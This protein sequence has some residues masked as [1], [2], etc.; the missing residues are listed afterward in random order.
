MLIDELKILYS[1]R[2]QVGITKLYDDCVIRI[3]QA[4]KMGWVDISYD[5]GRGRD[6]NIVEG[7]IG[8]FIAEGVTVSMTKNDLSTTLHFKGWA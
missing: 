4:V 7:V 2:Y 5:L 3:A 1:N 8:K 6:Q